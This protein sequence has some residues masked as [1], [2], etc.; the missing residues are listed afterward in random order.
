MRIPAAMAKTDLGKTIIDELTLCYDAEPILLADLSSIG[1]GCWLN[2]G[3]FSLYRVVSRNFQYG[4]DVL[5]CADGDSRMK[6]ATIR[7]GHY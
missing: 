7:F 3:E 6:L 1:I 5:Y 2:F 4:F